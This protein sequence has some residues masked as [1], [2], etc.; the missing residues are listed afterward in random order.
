MF[1]NDLMATRKW[2]KETKSDFL[3]RIWS[4]EHFNF[5]RYSIEREVIWRNTIFNLKLYEKCE[6]NIQFT[7]LLLDLNF[8]QKNE[9]FSRKLFALLPDKLF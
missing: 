6:L 8:G 1:E 9:T 3:V 2:S 5:K 4:A 7:F